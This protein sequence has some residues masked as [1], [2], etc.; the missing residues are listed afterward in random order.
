M[1]TIKISEFLKALRKAK[2]YTQEAVAKTLVFIGLMIFIILEKK[3]LKKN[4][5]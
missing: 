5:E 2:R 4:E 3:K 1:D